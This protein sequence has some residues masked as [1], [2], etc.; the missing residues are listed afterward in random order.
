[1]HRCSQLLQNTPAAGVS[2]ASVPAE[3]PP[4][5][6]VALTRSVTRWFIQG[7]VVFRSHKSR[8][9]I[10]SRAAASIV[11]VRISAPLSGARFE[12]SSQAIAPNLSR[13]PSQSAFA[14]TQTRPRTIS[15]LSIRSFREAT[16]PLWSAI[17]GATLCPTSS[18]SEMSK[19]SRLGPR[20]GSLTSCRNPY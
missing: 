8:C 9:G 20:V 5:P 1:M 4:A 10:Y 6:C 12:R 15:V 2:L 19:S 3:V 17:G 11:A 13:R 14:K 7:C 16:T 18:I